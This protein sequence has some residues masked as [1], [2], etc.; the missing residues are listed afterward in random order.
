MPGLWNSVESE[1]RQRKSLSERVDRL[2]TIYP[3]DSRFTLL[4]A[5]AERIERRGW[6]LRLSGSS[7]IGRHRPPARPSGATLSREPARNPRRA[8]GPPRR[9]LGAAGPAPPSGAA[10]RPG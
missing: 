5:C 2:F 6:T 10:V 4:V 9:P 8:I 3:L 7:P 1:Q